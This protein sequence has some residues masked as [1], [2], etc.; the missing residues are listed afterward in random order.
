M[1]YNIHMK[2]RVHIKVKVHV[3]INVQVKFKF[4][5]N[6]KVHIK[7]KHSVVSKPE[8]VKNAS[9]V[10]KLCIPKMFALKLKLQLRCDSLNN[11][12]W[13]CEKCQIPTFEMYI[14]KIAGFQCSK[15]LVLLS[16][17]PFF[18][19]KWTNVPK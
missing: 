11:T 15:F 1:I 14:I 16:Y 18:W 12:K 9:Q 3:K 8:R 7:I 17:N 6:V 13:K 2:V 10:L 4:H 19:L 5:V